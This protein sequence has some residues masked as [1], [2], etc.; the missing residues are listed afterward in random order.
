MHKYPSY[1]QIK[2]A[3]R[4]KGIGQGGDYQFD[5]G[6]NKCVCPQCGKKVIHTRR[7]PCSSIKCP[8][9]GARMIGR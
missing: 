9:C 3:E 5:F 4:G 7:V 8:E 1:D 2:L 6:A